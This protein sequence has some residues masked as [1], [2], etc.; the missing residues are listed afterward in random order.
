MIKL[1]RC[2]QNGMNARVV[3]GSEGDECPI[4]NKIKQGCIL[5]PKLFSFLLSMM[6]LS[7]FKDSDSGIKS[8]YR[9]DGGNFNTQRL[10]AKTKVTKALVCDLLYADD[11]DIVTH[12]EDDLQRLAG[13]LSA[14]T[15]RF[16]LSITKTEVMFQ[17][18]KGSRANMPEIKIDDKA[19]NNVDSFIYLGSSLSSSNSLDKEVSNHIAKASAS[20]GRLH[21]R[22]WNERGLKLKTKCTVYTAIVLTVLLYRCKSW[23]FY[24]RYVK[25]LDQIYQC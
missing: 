4:T 14:A 12:S 9:T 3:K 21:K 24:H 23:T 7:A 5:A 6:L 25:L 18:A 1:I 11:C 2:F 19:P 17:P 20:Y 8:T 22:V 10:K 16:E 15:K 13:S